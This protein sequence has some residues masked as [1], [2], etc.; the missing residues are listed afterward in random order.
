MKRIVI[1]GGGT[2]G[3]VFPALSIAREIRD[4]HPEA[5]ILFVGARDK[6]EMKKVPEAGFPIRG[7]WISGWQRG[8][9]LGNLLFPVKLVLSLMRC[10][11]ILLAFRPQ[12]AIG[13]GGFASGPLL[14][15][16]SW[17][18]IPYF[19]QEQNSFPGITNKLLARRARKIFVAYEG[20]ERFFPADRIVLTGNPIR[21]ELVDIQIDPGAARERLGLDRAKTTLLVLGGSL[22]AGRINELL[23][24]TWE[25]ITAMGLQILWQ[26][27]PAYIGQYGK[28]QGPDVRVTAFIDQM[29]DAFAA[30]DIIVSRSGA[31][32]VSELMLQGKATVFIPSPNVAEDHQTQNARALSSRGAA[33]LVTEDELERRFVP[34]LEKLV[35][36]TAYRSDLGR[37]MKEMAKPK[38]TSV[39]VDQ[40]EDSL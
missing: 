11:G 18:G 35:G 40:I 1:S 17:L 10:V 4:R 38:A 23:E 21:S 37:S 3:H 36:D 19:L 8:K 14:Q 16:A 2:G 29:S 25:G 22:G 33:V 24:K 9:R 39:I 31:G 27:G 12:L 5:S 30:A 13:T 15:A 20:L 34:E 28:F 6:I 32:T 7:L 26:C